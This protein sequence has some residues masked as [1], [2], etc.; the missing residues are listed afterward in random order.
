MSNT[1][2]AWHQKPSHSHNAFE[3]I[4]PRTPHRLSSCFHILRSYLTPPFKAAWW[5]PPLACILRC[6]MPW[7]FLGRYWSTMPAPTTTTPSSTS[8]ASK[9]SLRENASP[10]PYAR[11]LVSKVMPWTRHRQRFHS[12]PLY[13]NRI[14]HF[15][16]KNLTWQEQN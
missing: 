15:H 8:I 5:H 13:Y 11:N 9:T 12:H 14:L 1:S 2:S 7:T 16:F 4:V 6:Y 3:R 10:C